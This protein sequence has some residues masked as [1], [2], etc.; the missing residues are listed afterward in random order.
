MRI[1]FCLQSQFKYSVLNNSLFFFSKKNF[2]KSLNIQ[3][4]Y[5]GICWSSCIWQTWLLFQTTVWNS[6]FTTSRANLE[7]AYSCIQFLT[8]SLDPTANRQQL[9]NLKPFH[10]TLLLLISV[11]K[12]VLKSVTIC[13]CLRSLF[14]NVRNKYSI[15]NLACVLHAEA[16]TSDVGYATDIF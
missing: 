1:I 15:L 7:P 9:G 5:T 2:T 16:Y 3:V 13:L 11:S 6:L 4:F 14:G 8:R 10:S 12:I